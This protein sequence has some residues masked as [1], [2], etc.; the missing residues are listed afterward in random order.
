MRE[1]FTLVDEHGEIGVKVNVILVDGRILI[2]TENGGFRII[3]LA[4]NQLILE[5]V[6]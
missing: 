4:Q 5:V 1:V 6:R 2:D 3:P